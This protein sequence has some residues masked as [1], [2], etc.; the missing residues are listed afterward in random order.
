[1][2]KT[3]TEKAKSNLKFEFPLITSFKITKDIAMAGKSGLGDCKNNKNMGE[4]K[5][6]LHAFF[7]KI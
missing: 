2:V 7:S 1:M 6:K 5:S 3:K 4:V